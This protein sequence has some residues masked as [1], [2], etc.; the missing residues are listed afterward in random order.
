MSPLAQFADQVGQSA[1]GSADFVQSR[2]VMS[3]AA[4]ASFELRRLHAVLGSPGLSIAARMVRCMM[5]G[6]R[7]LRAQAVSPDGAASLA[8]R[9][10]HLALRLACCE[11]GAAW[12][13]AQAQTDRLRQIGERANALRLRR[14][15]RCRSKATGLASVRAYVQAPPRDATLRLSASAASDARPAAQLRRSCGIAAVVQSPTSLGHWSR[16]A[17]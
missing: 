13:A 8:M 17:V 5:A 6:R 7:I 11:R 12:R 15:R 3:V 9:P 16:R 14:S 1:P 10:A 4:D 2:D